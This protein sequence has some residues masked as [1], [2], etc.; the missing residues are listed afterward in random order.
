MLNG[1][2]FVTVVALALAVLTISGNTLLGGEP[3]VENFFGGLQFSTRAMP[4][5]ENTAT[6]QQ[7]AYSGN[8]LNP[9]MGSGQFFSAPQY[10][11]IIAPRFSNLNYGANIKYNMPDRAN[12]ASPCEPLTF[13]NMAKENYTKENYGCGTNPPSCG[14]G[15]YGMGAKVGGDDCAVPPGYTNGNYQDVYNSLRGE[16]IASSSDLP[17]A[18]MS[19][20]DGFGNEE[21]FVA[22]NRIMVANTKSSSRLRAQGDPIRG[23]LAIVPC[24]TGWFSTY[25]DIAR[26]IQEGAMNVLTD[27]APTSSQDSLYKLV[28]QASGGSQTALAGVNLADYN[29]ASAVNVN[30]APQSLSALAAAA[31]DIQVS[32][33]P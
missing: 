27:V 10:Q 4:V 3:V 11:A 1:K 6:G 5:I 29:P 13:G 30:M 33:F 22:F 16:S 26:D 19:A 9:N 25:P 24:Q 28:M 14:K 15:G 20:M 23:D 31:S 8:Y 18:S 21:Q 2:L 7:S 17:I 32:S 12:M